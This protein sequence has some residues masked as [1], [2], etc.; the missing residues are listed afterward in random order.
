[1]FFETIGSRPAAIDNEGLRVRYSRSQAQE[2]QSW[3]TGS[4]RTVKVGSREHK[5]T[6]AE[7]QRDGVTATGNK[8]SG[9]VGSD[10]GNFGDENS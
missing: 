6:L 4:G 1:M 3:R 9:K 7:W 8:K 2:Q 10:E 5:V